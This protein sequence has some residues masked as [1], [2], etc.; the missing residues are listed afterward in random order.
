M[1]RR[2]SKTSAGETL[3]R[4]SEEIPSVSLIA[5]H[6]VASPS[7]SHEA[8][9][10]HQMSTASSDELALETSPR[11]PS[12]DHWNSEVTPYSLP[13]AGASIQ[14]DWTADVD[15]LED[16]ASAQSRLDPPSDM[17][18]P[19]F[20]L[21][22]LPIESPTDASFNLFA[23]IQEQDLSPVVECVE[24][25]PKTISQEALLP[26]IDVYFKRLHSTVPVLSRTMI[27]QEM[28]LRTHHHDPQFGAMLLGLCAFAMTQPVQIHEVAS[29][30]SRS[31]QARMLLEE[32][33]KMRMTVDFG[34]NPSVYMI[35]TSFFIFACLFGS[36]QHK[37]AHHRL[38]EAVDLANTLSMH[39]PQAYDN[40][41]AETREQWLRTYLV[42]SVTER[43]YAL[44]KRHSIGFRG[45]PAVNAYFMRA[46]SSSSSSMNQDQADAVGMTGLLY[47]METF[48]AIDESVVE[49]WAGYC[50][51]SDGRC[52]TFDR[53][54]AVRMFRAQRRAREGCIVGKLSF[55][56]S[57]YLIP[58][59]Q[60]LESQR[61]DISVTQFWL[62]NRLWELCMSHGLL[63]ESSDHVEL[64]Y[65]F[66]YH[67]ANELLSSCNSLSLSSMEVH[68]VGLIEKVYD[69]AMSLTK[70]MGSSTQMT[71]DSSYS[72]LDP[73]ADQSADPGPSVRL[74][75]QKL[76]KLIQNFRGGDHEYA[77]RIATALSTIQDHGDLTGT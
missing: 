1:Q 3:L 11:H 31:V 17:C 51:Y 5:R 19:K 23:A 48:D 18:F 35:L 2:L 34:E 9:A 26:W 42:L 14:Q 55:E 21:P 54:Q 71:L 8:S 40:L 62:L 44:Q 46:F 47:L 49:C 75:L 7:S 33:I 15:I 43:A 38:R 59:P 69:I 74:L 29:T 58:L 28:L 67:V 32:S 27:Y 36:G 57:A 30:P 77:S 6:T 22:S 60:L 12:L 50:K 73:L 70:A 56:P 25:W 76:C 10:Q 61:A 4:F 72:S 65:D 39:L 24:I 68:G 41:D 37:A 20:L 63:L 66:A 13:T 52:E 64:R 16:Q 53:R 45:S